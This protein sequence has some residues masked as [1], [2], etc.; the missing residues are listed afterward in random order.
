MP[1]KQHIHLTESVYLSK[2]FL[3]SASL[4]DA[5]IYSYSADIP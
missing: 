3:R 4:K 1:Y 5:P 2:R